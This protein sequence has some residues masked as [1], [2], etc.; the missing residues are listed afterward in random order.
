ME[1]AHI[2]SSKFNQAYIK[3]I[4]FRE[5]PKPEE[6]NKQLGLVIDQ[7]DKVFSAVK[8]LTIRVEKKTKDDTT[9]II[10]NKK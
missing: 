6:L 2:P 3:T 4:K 8:N 7:F 5:S 9:S 10:S 1:A